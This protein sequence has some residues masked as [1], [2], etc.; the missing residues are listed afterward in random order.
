MPPVRWSA[1]IAGLSLAAC[2]S[3]NVDVYTHA[4]IYTNSPGAPAATWIAVERGTIVGIGASEPPAGR[5]IDLGGATVVPGLI[6]AH[7][8]LAGLGRSLSSM[9]LV[10]AKSF[11]EMLERV[12]AWP[13]SGVW[14]VGRGWNQEL[15]P[16]EK[17]P[18]HERLDAVTGDVPALL[19]RVDGHAGLANAAAMKLAG[20]TRDT[21]D[22]PGGH[23]LRE[24]GEPTGVLVDDAMGLVTRLIPGATKDDVKR[25]LLAAQEACLAAGLTGVHDAG[26]DATTLAAYREIDLKL[27]V[28]AMA[29][30]PLAERV[31]GDRFKLRCVKLYLDG[32]LGSRG[33][34]LLE[35]Y[36]DEPGS[37]GLETTPVAEV[38]RLA[39]E[40]SAK[41]FQI[42]I[43]AIGDRANR[44]ALEILK[45][46]DRGRIE[47][48]QVVAVDDIP[49]FRQYGVIASMQP[50]HATSD[51]N[52]AEQRVGPE[53]IK[54]AY[55]W[56]KMLDAGVAFAGGSDFPVESHKPLWGFYAAIARQ[57]HDGN[58]PGGW[59]AEEKLTRAE[60][61]AAF[62]SGAAYA[63]FDE[64]RLGRLAP[65]FAAD[66]VVLSKDIMTC[67]PR[68]VLRAEVLRT[69][70]AGETVWKK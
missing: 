4:T 63:G 29:T 48:A 23:L 15:W 69:V 24:R 27:R 45:G 34:R 7:G 3:S 28:Y 40:Y 56:R 66:F 54:G 18:T 58:P 62:T 16:D 25:H 8:H 12:K 17:M 9:N 60:A 32:A 70:I 6:D 51:M 37:T 46:L 44:E 53:R 2:A 21:A 50:T 35:P 14:I 31:G 61:L 64:N 22:P 47:H 30:P 20:I 42:A 67:E 52:M 5:V 33:A 11:D 41:G 49:K 43:H 39:R 38:R 26:I 13:R 1:L 68:D 59:R 19:I 10:G 65:G 57:D 36:L 55:A